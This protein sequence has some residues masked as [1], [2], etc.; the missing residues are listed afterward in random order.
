M[1]ANPAMRQVSANILAEVGL[2]KATFCGLIET[3]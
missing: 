2:G 1:C 3:K